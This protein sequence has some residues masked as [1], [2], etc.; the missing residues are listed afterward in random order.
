VAA[1]V[2]RLSAATA[3]TWVASGLGSI[4]LAGDRDE[5]T[6][7]CMG[8]MQCGEDV[9]KAFCKEQTQRG[10]DS[11]FS[12]QMRGVCGLWRHELSRLMCSNGS[13]SNG[14]GS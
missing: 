11:C 3:S 6:R 1:G 8:D 13:G 7:M 14:S 12:R 5:W 10:E 9:S 4:P 2:L